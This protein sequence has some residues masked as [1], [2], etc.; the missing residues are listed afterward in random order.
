LTTCATWIELRTNLHD[1]TAHCAA[2][3]ALGHAPGDP[4]DSALQARERS[5]YD[6]RR[7]IS[8]GTALDDPPRILG[9]VSCDMS[10]ARLGSL[11]PDGD[12]RCIA[13]WS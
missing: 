10:L 11:V 1:G 4:R 5:G 13:S 7:T 6:A 2:S 12:Y 9:V 3:P 8:G